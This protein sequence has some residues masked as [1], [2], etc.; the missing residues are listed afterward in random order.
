MEER[1]CEPTEAMAIL[2]NDRVIT[3]DFDDNEPTNAL[4]YLINNIG[5]VMDFYASKNPNLPIENVFLTGDGA[6]LR[7]LMASLRFS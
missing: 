4:R 7:V 5:R 3:A 2:E 1:G 6:R